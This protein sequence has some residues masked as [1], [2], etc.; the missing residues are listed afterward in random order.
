MCTAG[1]I[2]DTFRS[3]ALQNVCAQHIRDKEFFVFASGKP[4]VCWIIITHCHRMTCRDFEVATPEASVKA[5][6]RGQSTCLRPFRW[7]I[8]SR[9][10]YNQPEPR[11]DVVIPDHAIL[12]ELR[13]ELFPWYGE[14]K[15]H[16]LQAFEETCIK[17][18]A[19]N[20]VAWSDYFLILQISDVNPHSKNK[21]EVCAYSLEYIAFLRAGN[22]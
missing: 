12:T 7:G 20:V 18:T 21:H 8:R 6:I 4:A 13:H 22:I 19:A 2:F 14:L 16:D 5:V 3:Q 1:V 15:V 10:F 9:W 11:L 17:Q